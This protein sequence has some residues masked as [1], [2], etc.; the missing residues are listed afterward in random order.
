MVGELGGEKKKN[1]PLLH[2]KSRNLMS[3]FS[4]HGEGSG[5]GGQAPVTDRH[6]CVA[7]FILKPALYLQCL[8]LPPWGQ[9]LVSVCSQFEYEIRNVKSN[10]G[11][12]GKCVECED[13]SLAGEEKS[14]N[15]SPAKLLLAEGE[16]FILSRDKLC[17]SAAATET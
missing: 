4:Q 2:K 10:C 11:A 3:N 15:Q 5:E 1:K 14:K 13:L 6:I 9:L 12:T 16:R 17:P 7:L 8:H